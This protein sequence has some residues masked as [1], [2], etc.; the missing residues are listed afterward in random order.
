MKATLAD[1]LYVIPK[2]CWRPHEGTG[3]PADAQ[4]H[5]PGCPDA[6]WCRGNR[7]CYWNCKNDGLDE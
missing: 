6:E 7:A 3:I 2:S 5:P 4:M 1:R